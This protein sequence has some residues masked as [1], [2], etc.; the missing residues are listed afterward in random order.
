VLDDGDVVGS[1]WDRMADPSVE[2]GGD[3]ARCRIA[4]S[5]GAILAVAPLVGRS[6]GGLEE[7]GTMRP[8]TGMDRRA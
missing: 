7:G 8:L 2:H 4:S 6:K 3:L 5:L 1:E